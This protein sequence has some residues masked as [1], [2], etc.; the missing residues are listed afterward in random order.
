M[1]NKGNYSSIS[2]RDVL[3]RFV[4]CWKLV[5]IL[6]LAGLIISFMYVRKNYSS[7]E[8]EYKLKKSESEAVW[9]A[10]RDEAAAYADYNDAEAGNKDASVAKMHELWKSKLTRE[11]IEAVENTIGIKKQMNDLSK[12][13]RDSILMNLDAYNVGTLYMVWELSNETNSYGNLLTAYTGYA[14]GIEFAKTIAEENGFADEQY[15]DV[16]YNELLA[17]A[18]LNGSQFH[19]TYQYKDT[20]VLEKIAATITKLIENKNVELAGKLG[21]HSIKCIE[22]AVSVK[23]NTALGNSK[24]SYQQNITNYN[25][26]INTNKTKFAETAAQLN[27]YNSLADIEDGGTGAVKATLPAEPKVQEPK[28]LRS[29]AVYYAIGLIVGLIISLGTIYIQMLFSTKLQKTDELENIYSL[30]LFG[31]LPKKRALHIDRLIYTLKNRKQAPKDIVE[32]IAMIVGCISK[33][34]EEQGYKKL[35]IIGT[36]PIKKD[37]NTINNIISGL[38]EKGISTV[39]GGNIISDKKA[40]DAAMTAD[41]VLIIENIGVS[42]YRLVNRECSN[43]AVLKISTVGVIG[44]E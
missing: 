18:A 26:Q 39:Y 28:P 12:Y 4:E 30:K 38:K 1:D 25:N 6:A 42:A 43:M 15:D 19:I 23:S 24:N 3:W 37:E 9:K 44:L 8:H 31:S 16:I 5:V 21:Q 13:M 17:S 32:H 29:K 11:Q 22:I 20:A 2:L 14:T 34:C 36:N 35:T 7:L 10:Y 40:M 41:A 33:A 27:L